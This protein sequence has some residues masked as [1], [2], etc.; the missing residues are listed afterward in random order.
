MRHTADYCGRSVRELLPGSE[1]MRGPATVSALQ[2]GCTFRVSR[3]ISS[4]ARLA[5]PELQKIL[6]YT[7]PNKP[8]VSLPEPHI[9]STGRSTVS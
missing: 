2:N 3:A 6:R 9:F 5:H 8:L 7:P 1:A 4:P